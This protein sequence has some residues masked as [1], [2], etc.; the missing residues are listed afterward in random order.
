MEL[1]DDLKRLHNERFGSGRG[2]VLARPVRNR[3]MLESAVDGSARRCVE[4]LAH[5]CE[6][7]PSQ[8][9]LSAAAGHT[10]AAQGTARR[11]VSRISPAP[12]ARTAG[13][14]VINR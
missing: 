1:L 4:V 3:H 10:A 7:A 12:Y 9:P 5:A 13:R 14:D 6:S 11:R 8:V 2:E